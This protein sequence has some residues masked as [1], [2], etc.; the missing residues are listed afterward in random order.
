[1]GAENDVR[2]PRRGGGERGL[3]RGVDA[4]DVA[5]VL[6]QRHHDSVQGQEVR[7]DLLVGDNDVERGVLGSI[8]SLV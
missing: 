6:Q 3:T 2:Y 7:H 5:P 4:V 1:M 8:Y